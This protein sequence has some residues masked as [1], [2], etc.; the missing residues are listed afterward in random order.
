MQFNSLAFPGLTRRAATKGRQRLIEND[1]KA[2]Q[3]LV[4][5]ILKVGEALRLRI[6]D[7]D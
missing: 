3:L 5:M 2:D 4:E 1:G 7:L 6:A